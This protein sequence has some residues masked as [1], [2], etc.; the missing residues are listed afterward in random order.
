[1][2]PEAIE[3]QPAVDTALVMELKSDVKAK[4]GKP[5]PD[6]VDLLR[7]LQ[8]K[9]V[10]DVLAHPL[11]Q[12]Y[13]VQALENFQWKDWIDP[14]KATAAPIVRSDTRLKNHPCRP[15]PISGPEG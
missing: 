14:A 11:G 3:G 13:Q 6:Q 5:T 2:L 4:G 7:Y 8:R 9:H 15:R 1:V 10:N 12:S